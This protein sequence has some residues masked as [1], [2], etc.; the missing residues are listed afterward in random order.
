MEALEKALLIVRTHILLAHRYG[1]PW[2][3]QRRSWNRIAHG[4]LQ[5]PF[6]SGCSWPMRWRYNTTTSR[7][8]M[9]RSS[10]W[11]PRRGWD[12]PSCCTLLSSLPHPLHLP[13]FLFS[14]SLYPSVGQRD[15]LVLGFVSF[16]D[17]Q[18]LIMSSSFWRRELGCRATPTCLLG[19]MKWRQVEESLC[20]PR[21][22][23]GQ[24][25]PRVRIPRL[26]SLLLFSFFPYSF[27]SHWL[28]FFFPIF[29]FSHAA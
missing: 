25:P 12:M 17:A 15:I 13:F 23:Q 6:R 28:P 20:Q 22:T 10:C 24:T 4:M 3:K 16:P 5:R 27:L 1:R 8:K 11:W 14:A 9:P 29:S 21:L 19:K 2:G 18:F 7:S 26:F